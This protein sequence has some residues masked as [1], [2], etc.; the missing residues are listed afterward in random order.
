[1]PA[2]DWREWR[3]RFQAHL[4]QYGHTIYDLDFA[5]P[6]PADD[7]AP[8]L[9]AGKLYVGGGGVDPHAR[10]R[11]AAE[12]RER[13]TAALEA[14]RGWRARL[15]RRLLRSAQANAPIRE[16]GLAD[17]GLAY[18]YLRQA[19]GELGRRCVEAGAI[20]RSEDVYWLTEDEVGA[21][22]ERLDRGDAP[23][24]SDDVVRQRKADG[25]AARRVTPPLA[26]T[27]MRIL[28]KEIV[29]TRRLRASKPSDQTLRGVAASPGKATAPAAVISG[30]ED[31]ARMRTGDVLV[32]P[33]TTPAWTP[34]FARASAIVT[35]VGGPLSHGS[36][37]AREYGIPAVLGTDEATRRIGDG[38]VVTVD[39]SAGVVYLTTAR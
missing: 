36:I 10:Q 37:V 34:L 18:P 39:G 19:L 22:A 7:P 23:E 17:V 27:R 2:D 12:R 26:I 32:A 6:V 21:A 35:D 11:A 38:Q 9:E 20:A 16:D 15:C 33:L 29:K 25:R 31:F 8:L 30:P 28:G 5:N 14:R 13:A 24:S 3:S 1:M 4:R